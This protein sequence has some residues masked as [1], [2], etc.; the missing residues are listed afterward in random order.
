MTEPRTYVVYMHTNVLT[1]K[2]YVGITYQGMRR[3]WKQHVAQATCI[4]KRN[5]VRFHNAIAKHGPDCWIH[6]VLETCAGLNEANEAEKKWIA[7]LQTHTTGYNST[8]GGD[9]VTGHV[10]SEETRGEA[11]RG[12]Q[13][14]WSGK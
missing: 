3:R 9:G 4:A 7:E 2:S 1:G 6:S 14:T 11:A 5:T 8:I 10:A 12:A 13:E